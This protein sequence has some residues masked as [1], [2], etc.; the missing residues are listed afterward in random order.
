MIWRRVFLYGAQL[1][2]KKGAAL[3]F[4]FESGLLENV[5]WLL[6][7]SHFKMLCVTEKSKM[8]ANPR[9]LEE[10]IVSNL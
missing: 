2:N 8:M 7:N 4:S 1:W 6:F 10:D 3:R 5:S 9:A